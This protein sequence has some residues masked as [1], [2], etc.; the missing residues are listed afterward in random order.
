MIELFKHQQTGVEVARQNKRF[1]YF[2]QPGTGKTMTMLGI[3]KER[4]M[5]TLVVATKSILWSAWEKDAEVM[6]VPLT[7]VHSSNRNKREDL[8]REE[9]D[10]ILATN[11]EQFRANTD[12]FIK[13]GVKRV[14]FDES[15]KLKN[16]QAKTTQ[17]A[18]KVSDTCEEVYL[19][20]G[21]PTPNCRTELWSQLRCV[22]P[23][24]AGPSFWKWAYYWFIPVTRMVGGRRTI[25]R[26]LVNPEREEAFQHH[27]KEWSWALRKDECLD[28]PAQMDQVVQVEL[29]SAERKYYKEISEE[30][31]ITVPDGIRGKSLHEEFSVP[32]AV[33]AVMMKLRQVC[34]GTVR[35]GEGIVEI[36]SSKIDAM[37]NILEDIGDEPVVIWAEFTADID[38]IA[39]AISK[40]GK[41]TAIIDGRT[42]H[43]S[44]TVVQDF[45]QGKIDRLILHPK[46]AGHGTDG[47]QKVCK[48][49]MYYSLSFSADEHIQSRD[50]IH[51]SGQHHP[52]TYIYLI[53]EDT[54]E[55]EML[56]VVRNK[57]SKQTALLKELRM[58]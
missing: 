4:P 36:G 8:I 2:W 38:R 24:A 13:S 21:S 34:N 41:T 55:R 27:L 9:G 44:K 42:S 29:S 50:R 31:K 58:E 35:A 28:L 1:A 37:L 47:L 20:S 49:A 12:L 33:E 15:S 39:R 25:D 46:A 57:S 26:W 45:V 17:A 10:H 23:A 54:L 18:I 43:N 22:S 52:C 56:G 51:R 32:V 40:T 53:A 48:Y 30:L 19:L 7:V 11:Y 14:I 5:R 16:R 6:G 3:Y